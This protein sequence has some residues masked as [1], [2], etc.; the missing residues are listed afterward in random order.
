MLDIPFLQLCGIITLFNDIYSTLKKSL[1]EG[2]NYY[3]K[4]HASN[5]HL[6]EKYKHNKNSRFLCLKNEI[7]INGVPEEKDISNNENDDSEK[8]KK[9]KKYA[10]NIAGHKSGMKNKTCIFKTK[11]YS[12]L[13]KKIFKELDYTSF[14]QNNR[15][16]I[17]VSLTYS[18]SGSLLYHLGLKKEYL[19]TLAENDGPWSPIVGVLKNLGDLLQHSVPGTTG[20]VKCNWCE[21]ASRVSD[22]CILGNFFRILIYFVPFV[23]L[24]ITLISGIFYYHKKVKKYEK[25]KFE[26][27]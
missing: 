14:L 4:L 27:R 23:L 19:K 16:I 12:H 8:K 26:K 15:T 3:R 25:I 18:N 1:D 11:K 24:S 13:E 5:Y 6:L 2:D 9:S 20:A 10:S 21:V 22:M 17:E 7:Q